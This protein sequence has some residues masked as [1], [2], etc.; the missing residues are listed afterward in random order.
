MEKIKKAVILKDKIIVELEPSKENYVELLNIISLENTNNV[1]IDLNILK[2]D[3]EGKIRRLDFH[4]INMGIEFYKRYKDVLK[5]IKI[6][7][8]EIEK[9][10]FSFGYS[11]LILKVFKDLELNGLERIRKLVEKSLDYRYDSPQGFEELLSCG[12]KDLAIKLMKKTIVCLCGKPFF[13]DAIND[14]FANGMKNVIDPNVFLNVLRIVQIIYSNNLESSFEKEIE[15]L[16]EK[17]YNA[18]NIYSHNTLSALKNMLV[19]E[20]YREFGMI[21]LKILN[22]ENLKRRILEQLL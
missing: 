6:N 18:I 14:T 1:E 7:F 2:E 19:S 8:D 9:C 5:E 12:E 11:V 21:I 4:K 20:Y 16:R 3:I 17:I 13:L 15:M 22:D 10:N